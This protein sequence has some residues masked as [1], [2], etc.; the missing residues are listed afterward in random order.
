MASLARRA[1]AAV[2][3]ITLH[4]R[5]TGL[6]RRLVKRTEELRESEQRLRSLAD[7]VPAMI[8]M[9]GADKLSTYFN[10]TWSDFTGRPLDDDVGC[11]WADVGIHPGDV[12]R[13]L[14]TYS[15]MFDAREPFRV[16]YRLRRADGVYRWVLDTGTPQFASF[17]WR[18][19]AFQDLDA[20]EW[21]REPAEP[22]LSRIS[23]QAK[24]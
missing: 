19:G 15:T 21:R 20:G 23:F 6:N 16:E 18:S 12:E 10:Q 3:R 2:T 11:G 17:E 5:V 9:T 22:R 8:W 1:A 14:E 24:E 7:T 13:A 4:D